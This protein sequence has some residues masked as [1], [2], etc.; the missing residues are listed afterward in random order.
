[1][2]QNGLSHFLVTFFAFVLTHSAISSDC[3]AQGGG[4]GD[5]VNPTVPLT[6]LQVQNVFVPD[7]RGASGYSNQFILQPVMPLIIS[8]DSDF[9]PFHVIRPTL[10]IIAPSPD[11]DGPLESQG[12]LGDLSLFDLYVQPVKQL[13]TNFAFGYT[14][15]LPT[16][17]DRQ[18]GLGEWQFGPAAAFVSTAIPKWVTGAIAQAPF[19]TESDA[20][21]VSTQLIATRLLEDEWYVGWG[22][23]LIVLDD[24]NGNYDIPIS[25][26]LGKIVK[27]G[28]QPLNLALQGRYTPEGFQ[29]SPVGTEWGIKLNVTL[30]F[31][32]TKLHDPILG[33]FGCCR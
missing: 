16:S 24:Q 25:L 26:R 3:Q 17:T 10:P 33:G 2:R 27:W 28:D 13:K 9:L 30:L 5:A 4:A 22:D 8:E 15:V 1:M 31:P 12:G 32:K 18:L 6:Q 7:T 20:Y 29:S 14:A 23:S 19:S 11:P 21:S